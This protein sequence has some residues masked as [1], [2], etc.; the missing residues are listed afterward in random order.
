[1]ALRGPSGCEYRKAS[2]QAQVH[3][4]DQGQ[5]C[6]RWNNGLDHGILSVRHRAAAASLGKGAPLHGPVGAAT[7][8]MLSSVGPSRTDVHRPDTLDLNQ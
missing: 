1:M 2:L 7:A 5:W 4:G 3:R 6:S 8:L